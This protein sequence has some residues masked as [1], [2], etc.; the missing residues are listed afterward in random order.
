MEGK[1]SISDYRSKLDKTLTSPDLT[2]YET[3]RTHVKNQILQSLES[4]LEEYTEQVVEKRS[5][6][7]FSL[8]SML[9]S[10]SVSD[11]DKS[12]SINE[13]QSCWK[14]KEDTDE[15][16]VM[17][18]EGPA[19]TPFHTLLVE[20]YVDGPL[21]ISDLESIERS[22][23]GFT[24]DGIPDAEDVVRIDVVGGFALQKVTE[25]RSY[26]RTIA[27]MDIKLDFI[28]P[29]FINFISRQLVGSGF[30]LYKKEVAS[31]SKGDHKFLEALNDP[32][33]I[34]V[35]E[36]LYSKNTPLTSN[37]MFEEQNLEACKNNNNSNE[38]NHETED[39]RVRERKSVSEIEELEITE[40]V[41]TD[42]NEAVITNELGR[43]LQM[44]NSITEQFASGN[45]RK[46]GIISPRVQEALMT[47]DK[48]ISIL[49]E[50]NNNNNN[51]IHSRQGQHD[52][53]S[54]D[55]RIFDDE[56]EEELFIS[57]EADQIRKKEYEPKNNS[58]SH[59][60]R[61][62]GSNSYSRD[63]KPSKIAPDE[64]P[65]NSHSYAE[66][67]T[68]P[69]AFEN[70]TEN[71]NLLNDDAKITKGKGVTKRKSH[72]PKFCCFVARQEV[73]A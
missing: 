51:N 2:N 36:A 10:A 49:R 11:L 35:R 71:V 44:A 19:G 57:L 45:V 18:R 50:H 27:N 20:G 28:P 42:S 30:K 5:K 21:D 73:Q 29:A 24:R 67:I 9:R 23:H 61:P 3:I 38:E 6:E 25:D 39:L 65:T 17:Y 34:R 41:E 16:R 40:E 63:T 15:F 14:V 12:K 72:F 33:Y 43:N 55:S 32:I 69:T 53:E 58:D 13:S 59:E 1:D 48:A 7:M 60:S 54:A 66:Q 52:V 22:T 8:L 37:G 62:R 31:A 46:I 4:D 47:L 56:K 64:S 70:I 26:F 68:F